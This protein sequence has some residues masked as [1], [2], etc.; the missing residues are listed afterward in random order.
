[1]IPHL[2]KHRLF[3]LRFTLIVLMVLAATAD[4]RLSHA[5]T[6]D[7]FVI[8]IWLDPCM[9]NETAD[10]N[11]VAATNIDL[12]R[13][14]V[15]KDAYINLLT[16]TRITHGFDY[17]LYLARHTGLKTLLGSGNY[18][19]DS[20]YAA[21]NVASFGNEPAFYGYFVKDE[22]LYTDPPDVFTSFISYYRR[23]DPSHAAFLNLLPSGGASHSMYEAYVDQYLSDPDPYRN[24]DIAS[25]D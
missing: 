13:F 24:E 14:Q 18:A 21:S 1:M 23:H 19:Y 6:Q 22:P 12:G 17:Y 3:A 2:G 10:T 7:K 11:D 5:W 9:T 20:V 16:G 15:A 25:F 8:G 4:P